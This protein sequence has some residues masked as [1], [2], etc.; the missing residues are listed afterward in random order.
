MNHL[1]PRLTMAALG[2]GLLA[3]G[4]AC[5]LSGL[6]PIGVLTAAAGG[7]LVTVAIVNQED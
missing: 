2:M 6:I 1:V 3:L 4:S 5:I 7:A